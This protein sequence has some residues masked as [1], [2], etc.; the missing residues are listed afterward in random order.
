MDGSWVHVDTPSVDRMCTYS[1]IVSAILRRF[2]SGIRRVYVHENETYGVVEI[3]VLLSWWTLIF[4]FGDL[5][6][7][8]QAEIIHMFEEGRP[9][10]IMGDVRVGWLAK[11]RD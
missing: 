4:Y 10:G 1:E 3:E 2:P 6:D 8:M 9:V 7:E 5:R 11:R